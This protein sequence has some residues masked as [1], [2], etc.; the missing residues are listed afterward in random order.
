MAESTNAK[1]GSVLLSMEGIDKSFP[2]VKAL[3]DVDFTLRYGE[4]HAVMG[5]NGAGKSTL[6][7]VLTGV[8]HAEA[9]VT[10]LEGQ[11]YSARSPRSHAQRAGHQYG[12]PGTQPLQ[13][14]E[15]RREHLRRSRPKKLGRHRLEDRCNSAPS[16]YCWRMD[17]DVDV[18]QHAGYVPRRRA[19]DGRPSL[20][21]WRSPPKSSSWTSRP[22]AWT[23][24]NQRNCSA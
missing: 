1:N 4:I 10:T 2:G 19:A 14:P 17:L 23:H 22:Q 6:I 20:V 9:G 15:D 18:T 24:A 13:Q 3:Q 8:E 11:A 12:L 7:K 5:E 16:R 21:R